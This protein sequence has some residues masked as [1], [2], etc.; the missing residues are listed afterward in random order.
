ML[1]RRKDFYEVLHPEIKAAYWSVEFKEI[2]AAIWW[3]TKMSVTKKSFV[4][5]IAEELGTASWTV[6]REIQVA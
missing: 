6:R 2:S 1:L 4:Q 3:R 5:D